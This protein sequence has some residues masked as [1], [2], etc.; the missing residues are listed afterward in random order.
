M[1][2]RAA[3]VPDPRESRG[4]GAPAVPGADAQHTAPRRPGHGSCCRS[5]FHRI[6]ALRVG[7]SWL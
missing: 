6:A 7:L 5:V 2:I 3:R 1:R 4:R